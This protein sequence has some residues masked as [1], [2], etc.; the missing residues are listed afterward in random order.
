MERD[1]SQIRSIL[2]TSKDLV[3]E[4]LALIGKTNVSYIWAGLGVVM[5]WPNLDEVSTKVMLVLLEL[6]NAFD[7]EV[8]LVLALDAGVLSPSNRAIASSAVRVT[9]VYNWT[10]ATPAICELL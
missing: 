4:V 2:E 9:G 8:L 3:I 7:V 5:A 1:K 6:L 10:L